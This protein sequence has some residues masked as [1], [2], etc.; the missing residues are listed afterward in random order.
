[1]ITIKIKIIAGTIIQETS[2]MKTQTITG[3]QNCSVA[4]IKIH[5]LKEKLTRGNYQI[6]NICIHLFRKVIIRI[7]NYHTFRQVS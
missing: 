3:K 1:M 2:I 4:D 7:K 5:R 6:Q